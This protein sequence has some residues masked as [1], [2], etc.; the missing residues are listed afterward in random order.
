MLRAPVFRSRFVKDPESVR[1]SVA[2]VG[3][4]VVGLRNRVTGCV[5]YEAAVEVAPE[6]VCDCVVEGVGIGLV[7]KCCCCASN[8]CC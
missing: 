2:A 1:L 7:T 4:S 6:C 3:V 5:W 8:L